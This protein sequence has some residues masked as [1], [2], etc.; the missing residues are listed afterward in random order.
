MALDVG[1]VIVRLD[2]FLT[3]MGIGSRSEVKQGIKKGFAKVNGETAKRPDQKV[4]ET[5]QVSWKGTPVV[6]I[7]YEYIMLNKPAG[8]VSAT[9]DSRDKTVV[10]LIKDSL[11]K[12]LFPVGRLDKD[13]EG[14]LLLTNDGA[15][16]HRLLS[17]KHHVAKVY[18]AKIDG[19]M[20]EEDVKIFS[21]GFRVDDELD[22][23]PSKLKILSK[24]EN[25]C[26]IELEIYEGKFHQVKRM[27][28]AV[29][30]EV[31]YLK[32]LSMGN[33]TLD[34]CLKTGEYRHLTASELEG[35][36][37]S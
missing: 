7:E 21:E 1:D 35:L 37:V 5:D 24:T 4:V 36:N 22:A 3:E 11:R 29:G 25:T 34:E 17:P 33:L 19:V 18:Y 15:L 2:K 13:T 16:A 28:H 20:T 8:V 9:E 12:D 14:L 23:L 32:R 30:K 10:D 31:V 26:E 27:V 6:Y